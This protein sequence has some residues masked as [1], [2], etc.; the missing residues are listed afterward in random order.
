[1]KIFRKSQ[2][3]TRHRPVEQNKV[4]SYYSKSSSKP[5]TR[6]ENS[7]NLGRNAD[8]IDLGSQAK[9]GHVPTYIA[10]F[11]I[12]VAGLYA[13]W[14]KPQP[15]VVILGQ[16]NTI[17][18]PAEEY[19]TAI[20]SIWEESIF[21]QTKLTL[22]GAKLTQRL[23]EQFPELMQVNI[24]LPL[25][26]QRPSVILRP[27][28][29]ALSVINDQGTF[30]VDSSGKVLASADKVLKQEL[31]PMPLIDDKT[32]VEA[33]LGKQFLAQEQ[34]YFITS[35]Y[36]YL[37]AAAVPIKS[38]TMPADKA[39]EIHVAI[40]GEGY[41]LKFSLLTDPKQAVGMY[42]AVRKNLQANAYVDLRVPEKIFYK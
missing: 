21:N 15:K 30:Y 4:F 9:W 29:P 28:Q 40:E 32:G 5:V 12:T 26:G 37:R 18:R 11:L 1:M 33:E 35:L 19:Q 22:N 3:P 24:E 2:T 13:L 38:L 20:Q 36:T 6:G 10:L 42:L 39:H 7:G 17:H 34:V 41:Y 14:L 27:S 31:K 25:L 23:K 8:T 16:P